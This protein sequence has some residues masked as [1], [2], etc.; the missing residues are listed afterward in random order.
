MWYSGSLT[1]EAGALTAR[2]KIGATVAAGQVAILDDAG[3]GEITDPTTT[4]FADAI[5]VTQEAGT[6][7]TTQGTGA[8]TAEVLVYTVYNPFAIFRS[9]ISGAST[10]NDDVA[11]SLTENDVSS[12]NG[13]TGTQGVTDT[14]LPSDS[15]LGGL[16]YALSGGNKS[17]SRIITTFVS[18]GTLFVTV[19]FDNTIAS[20]DKFV[21]FGASREAQ[22]LEISTS[23]TQVPQWYPTATGGAAAILRVIVDD[24]DPAAPLAWLEFMFRD[25]NYNPLS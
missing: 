21:A 12:A 2:F 22:V 24:T 3:P 4:A 19:P 6:Y 7:S 11:L 13:G 20:G 10:G 23:F 17:Q 16:V 18:A 14:D 9:A 25:H 8:S 15:M 1:G 5:G